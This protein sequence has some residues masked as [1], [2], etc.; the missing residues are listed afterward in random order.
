[1]LVGVRF[2]RF[3]RLYHELIFRGGRVVWIIQYHQA[4]SEPPR[5]HMHSLGSPAM[6]C[7]G[8]SRAYHPYSCERIRY[9]DDESA[10]PADFH[11]P[12]AEFEN[13]AELIWQ[14]I[15][16]TFKDGSENPREQSYTYEHEFRFYEGLEEQEE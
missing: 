6:E 13:K 1:M 9:Y 16:R 15:R 14:V 5:G 4:G 10:D 12:P 7:P 2:E 3:P 11:Y 8:E